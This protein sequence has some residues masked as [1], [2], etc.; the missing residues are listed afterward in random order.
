VSVDA[1][2]LAYV[3][4]TSG[5]TGNPKG[6][7]GRHGPLTHFAAWAV[8]MF[9]LNQSDRFSMLS[10]LSH[11]P[12]HR[13]IFTPLQLGATICIPDSEDLGAPGRLAAWLRQQAITIANLTPAMGQFLG[14]TTATATG[15]QIESLRYTFL[16]GD[17]LTR[18]DVSRLRK[19]A[20]SLT[21]VNLYGA[22]ETQRAVGYFI[23]PGPA[24][25]TAESDREKEVL[26]LGK[27]IRDV[28]LVLLNASRQLA[29]I[30]EVGEI[31]F[32]SPHL[33]KGY[34]GD[35]LLTR[36][37]F[38]LNP[39]TKAS[40]DRL[41]RTG[42]L[43]RYL[44]D[45]NVEYLGRV[46]RQVKVRSFRIELGEVEAV[47]TEHPDVRETAVI[48][49]QNEFGETNLAAYVVPL[50][51]ALITTTELRRYLREKLPDYMIPAAFV[52][53][54]ALPLTPN[55]KVDRS[56]LPAPEH[57]R[58]E[59]EGT[60][61]APRTPVEEAVAGIWTEV[62]GLERVGINDNFFDLG[63]HS[64]LAVR[65]LSR[66]EKQFNQRIPLV[67][68][69]QGATIEDLADILQRDVR[70][71]SWPT[72]VEIQPGGSKPPLF[73]VSTPNV[74]ALGYVALARHLGSE[75]PVFGLQAQYPEDLDGEHSWAAIDKLATQYL[76]ALRALRPQGPYQFL[77]MCR[78]A[79][80]AHEMAIRLKAEGQD[81]AL[82]GVLDTWVV[83]N[84]YNWFLH[85]E[86]FCRRLTS[87]ARLSF[88]EQLRFVK[89]KTQSV[90]NRFGR[91]AVARASESLSPGRGNPMH[92]YFPGPEFV[93]KCYDGRISVFRIRR[94]PLNRIRDGGLGWAR[95]ATGGVEIHIVPGTHQTVLREPNVR[96]LAEALKKC[97]LNNAEQGVT[98]V[99]GR[100]GNH[101]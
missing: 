76:D 95:V 100:N 81:V 97:L 19:L 59:L 96:G 7:L 84:T 15:A 32:R 37:R 34:L 18:R 12:L 98:N 66:I 3:A 101:S 42:D 51:S 69:F 22:T 78:G 38:L 90:A 71:M 9:G 44:P 86:Y 6:I 85:I 91:G 56:A 28:Q 23:V 46:D 61:V 89:H 82:V 49:R 35:D 57:S 58:P 60:F 36:E 77:G 75:Q 53:M 10:G 45:G 63:G 87:L 40:G 27:G 48:A 43:G 25:A 99:T 16:V 31:Y 11:D 4:F 47:L 2:D 92:V 8:E 62:L 94:Q 52:M 33:A 14:E 5:S 64:L 39:F 83:E 79:H 30:G 72:L 68:L 50:Q 74:N 20:P 29:G 13:D 93:P 80:I 41:Y 70:S 21:C 67:S 54:A 24:E 26:P 65:L 55:R 88:K 73:C 1:D 17:V